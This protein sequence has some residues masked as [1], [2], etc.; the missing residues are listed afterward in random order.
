ML[1]VNLCLSEIPNEFRFKSLKNGKVYVQL[2][3][4]ERQTLG[5]FG[6]THFVKINKTKAQKEKD[7]TSI[8][9]GSAK[10]INF[11]KPLSENDEGSMEN[12]YPQ[13]SENYSQ[14]IANADAEF[15]QMM[16][17]PEPLKVHPR[18]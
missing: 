1:Q 10:E 16:N 11:E 18:Y 12:D 5:Q 9:C 7:K 8:Y 13:E 17:E 15:N 14:Q 3:I 2:L 4:G 6:E